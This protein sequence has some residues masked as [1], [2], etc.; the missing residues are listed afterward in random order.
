MNNLPAGSDYD[1]RAPWSEPGFMD[2]FQC[3]ICGEWFYSEDNLDKHM[4][5]EHEEDE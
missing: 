5:D 4:K 1:A 3:E 2:S